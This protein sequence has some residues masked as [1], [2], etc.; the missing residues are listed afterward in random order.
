[1]SHHRLEQLDAIA[2]KA[3]IPLSELFRQRG[4]HL[5]RC[6]RKWKCCCPFHNDSDPS[7][8]I[9]D[10]KHGG[11]YHCFPCGKGGDHFTFLMEYEGISF[12]EAIEMLGGGSDC[13]PR[14]AR[15]PT[16]IAKID[17]E[18]EG[19]RRAKAL[20][21]WNAAAPV[22]GTIAER[23]LL[24]R[25]LPLDQLPALPDL[26]F[27]RL[28]HAES[29]SALP[30]LIAAIRDPSGVISA[31]QRIW[32]TDDGHNVECVNDAG[33]RKKA[34][35]TLGPLKGNAIRLGSD[36]LDEIILCE[37]LETGLSI[38]FDC[39]DA[40]VWVAAGKGNLSSIALPSECRC[41]IIAGD[42]DENEGGQT[43]AREAAEAFKL[44]GLRAFVALP[45]AP[46]GDFNDMRKVAHRG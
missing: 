15:Q 24:N 30:A 36:R 23:Y 10:D 14:P 38:L 46:Y 12:G 3:A 41:V 16:K 20:E 28:W 5:V 1:M 13:S 39:P 45:P 31:I 34:K 27:D 42:R 19:R 26:R 8:E 6:G 32:I 25:G 29:R 17:D 21:I 22:V 9:D 7:L 18:D 43:A 2:L 37:G 35:K 4:F 11:V 40:A 33:K 44:A